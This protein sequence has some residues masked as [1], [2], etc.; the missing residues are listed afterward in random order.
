M[1]QCVISDIESTFPS[2]SEVSVRPFDMWGADLGSILEAPPAEDKGDDR[3]RLREV[4][5]LL[6]P[7]EGER[8][9]RGR[10]LCSSD[11]P[12]ANDAGGCEKPHCE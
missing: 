8:A 10:E 7:V 2:N 12:D 9:T 5:E 3:H 6:E 1:C 11:K 4:I